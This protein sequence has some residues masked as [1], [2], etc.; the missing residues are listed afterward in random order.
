MALLPKLMRGSHISQP[1]IT[2]SRVTQCQ[3][4]ATAPVPSHLDGE[5]Q[6]LQTHFEIELLRGALRLL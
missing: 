4:T 3:L 1:E 5:V 6:P 2:H